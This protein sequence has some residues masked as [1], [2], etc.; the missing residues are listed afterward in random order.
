MLNQGGASSCYTAIVKNLI[1]LKRA[2][3]AMYLTTG[4][5]SELSIE[6]AKKHVPEEN[7]IEVTNTKDSNYTKLTDPST[8]N[9]DVEASYLHVCVNETVHG[10]E[11]REDNF[12]W[13][14]FPEDTVVVGDMS[15]DIGTF[16]INWKR[17]DV[18][19]AGVQ[20]NLGPA[21]ANL[22]ICRKDLIGKAE[23]DVP[24]L[25]NWTVFEQ[26]PG[27]YYN[28]PPVWCI[29]VTGLNVCYMNQRGGVEHYDRMADA[30]SRMLYDL[31]D[32][33]DGYYVNKTDTNFRSRVNI[34]LRIDKDHTLEKKIIAEAAKNQIINISGHPANPG[35]RISVYNATPFEGCAVLC[36]FLDDFRKANPI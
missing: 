19:Y 18:I 2:R 27:Q 14:M 28:T 3:K 6:E 8:W 10:F 36:K 29:F 9:I 16:K 5:W 31:I 32:K 23:D 26:S 25:N 17:Y 33:S 12:P 20:K 21:G 34:V 1:G 30:K 35:L 4:L 24:I 7:I 13:Q 22:I 15:S 11:I